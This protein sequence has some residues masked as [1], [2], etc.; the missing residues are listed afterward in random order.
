MRKYPRPSHCEPGGFDGIISTII[1]LILCM[2]C[3]PLV[4]LFALIY[5]GY[6]AHEDSIKSV[7]SYVFIALI[8][9]L[10]TVGSPIIVIVNII[11]GTFI[12]DFLNLIPAL[13]FFL[14]EVIFAFWLTI[15]NRTPRLYNKLKI[16]IHNH[17]TEL[18]W[19]MYLICIIGIIACIAYFANDSDEEKD[20]LV[21]M[22]FLF[23]LCSAP[24][25]FGMCK[26]LEKSIANDPMTKA[27]NT[28]SQIDYNRLVKIYGKDVADNEL[29]NRKMTEELIK[30]GK[31]TDPRIKWEDRLNPK[32]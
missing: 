12:S 26:A 9:L 17:K 22:I 20:A 3:P 5:D 15:S 32:K 25:L 8:I 16:I 6:K 27:K 13:F 2:F 1:Y 4:F 30:T 31:C 28:A 7:L 23:C 14:L 24:L 19:I 11:Q 18:I 29:I 21:S 10:L